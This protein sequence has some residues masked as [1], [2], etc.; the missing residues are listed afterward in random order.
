MP[1]RR[2][3]SFIATLE[4]VSINGAH[5]TS[6]R[7]ADRV[8]IV[9]G[10]GRGIGRSIVLGLAE[11]GIRVVTTSA[12][13]HLEIEA[14]A[15]EA[16]RRFGDRRVLAL[17]GDV[18]QDDHCAKVI[19]AAMGQFGRVDVLVNNAGRGMK[20]VSNDFLTEPTRF[21]EVAPETWRMV[22]NTNV[23]GPFMMARHAVPLMLKAGWGRIVNISISDSTM[24]RRGF[25]PYGP[26][27]AALE[28]ETIIWAQD[29]EGTG[30]T[31]NSLLPGGATLTG[32]VPDALP[33]DLKSTLLDPSIVVPP[34]LWLLSPEADRTTGRRVVATKWRAG[35]EE[36]VTSEPATEEAGW[37]S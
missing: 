25:S 33:E 27:K 34:L 8:A 23:I 28:S 30:V 36:I 18:T 2:E 22:I 31:V 12:R 24:R 37:Q 10:G 21:W 5:M 11:A 32:M 35:A 4:S 9:T 26:S 13:E 20:Y 1:Y 17:V 15:G 19:E 14:V 3:D 7:V 29:L 6:T 16:N